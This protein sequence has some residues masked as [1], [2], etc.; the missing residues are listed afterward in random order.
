MLGVRG[1]VVAPFPVQIRDLVQRAQLGR[2]VAVAI[3]AKGHAQRLHLIDLVHLVDLAVALHATDAAVDVDRVVEIDIVR[4]PVNLHPGNRLPGLG[5]LPHQ[6][7]PRIILEHLAVAI[8]A[9]RA[10]RDVG[11]PRL[12]HPVMAVAAIKAQLVHMHRVRKGH[13]LNRLIPDP[14]VLGRQVIPHPRRDGGR[15]HQP[16]DEDHHRQSIRPLWEYR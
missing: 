4:H 14:R 9:G 7:Q 6:R 5:A 8:H 10:G 13:R 1:R 12:L 15:G 2:R 11:I 16:A 3:Q